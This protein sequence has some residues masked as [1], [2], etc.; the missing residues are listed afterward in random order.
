M[1]CASG[2]ET[3]LPSEAASAQAIVERFMDPDGFPDRAAHYTGEMSERYRDERTLGEYFPSTVHRSYMPLPVDSTHLV[4]S[5]ELRDGGRKENWYAHLLRDSVDWKLEAVRRLFIPGFMD[6]LVDSVRKMPAP[7]D[8]LKRFVD[9]LELVLASDDSL[10]SYARER[11]ADLNFLA[12][13]YLKLTDRKAVRAWRDE[14][15][16]SPTTARLRSKLRELHLDSVAD[17]EQPGGVVAMIGGFIDNAVGFVY[18]PPGQVPPK[19]SPNH[20][21]VVL[22]VAPNW[23]LFK[24]T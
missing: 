14:S 9:E 1:S 18:V 10:E 20:Y 12:T 15:G 5:I 17:S 7:P 16:D 8:S 3:K 2:L 21:I 4:I 22:P 23:Y 6:D 24:T 13:S 11:L 19:M